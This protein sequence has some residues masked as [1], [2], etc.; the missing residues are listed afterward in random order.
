MGGDKVLTMLA[1][2]LRKG[3]VMDG[4]GSK[5]LGW[6][7]LVT[8]EFFQLTRY[9]SNSFCHFLELLCYDVHHRHPFQRLNLFLY[10][11]APL[12]ESD[13]EADERHYQLWRIENGVAEGS[14]EIPKGN[15]I[16]RVGWSQSHESCGGPK[17]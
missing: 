14:T 3:T 5:I 1:S 16:F 11:T 15:F 9:V 4:N 10:L 12:V 2:Q 13:K 17:V 6:T 8:E 7:T